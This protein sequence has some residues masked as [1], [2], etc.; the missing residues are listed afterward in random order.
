MHFQHSENRVGLTAQPTMLA[1]E[2]E[3]KVEH[4][5]SWH[6]EDV[7]KFQSCKNRMEL[8]GQSDVK[9]ASRWPL[10]LRKKGWV[11]SFNTSQ[12]RTRVIQT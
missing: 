4:E 9:R 10:L 2:I 5:Q 7:G 8:G 3:R 11:L 1:K 12:K 6:R